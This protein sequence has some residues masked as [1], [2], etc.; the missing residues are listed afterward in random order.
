MHAPA[1]ADT[2]GH[3]S[4][5]GATRRHR[6]EIDGLRALAVSLV[7]AYHVFSGRVSGGVDVFLALS[8]FFLVFG[9][10]GQLRRTGEL[11]PLQSVSRTLSRLVPTAAVVLAGTTSAGL[12][13]MPENRWREL[14][15][16]LVASMTFTEN[17]LLVREAV[18]YSASNALASPMQ[19]FWSL[20][21]Q[22][23]VLVAAPVLAW[24]GV[25]L[26]RRSPWARHGHRIATAAVALVTGA[27]LLWSIHTTQADQQVAYFSMLPRLWELGAGALA[28]LLLTRVRPSAPV[29][30]VL[31][32]GGVLALVSCGALLDGA[33]QFPGW[34]AAWPVLS[35]V[36]VI[37][38]AHHGGPAG[39]HRFLSLPAMRWLGARSYALYLWHWPVLVLYLVLE[40]RE[41]PSAV[42][43]T[44][45]L[46][47]SVLLAAVTYRLVERPTAERLR[48]RRPLL[49]L[50]AVAAC[51]APLASGGLAATTWIERQADRIAAVAADPAYPGA[52]ALR[53]REVTTGGVPGVA[54]L[55]P[56][57]LIREDW[58]WLP[59]EATCTTE[60]R[61]GDPAPVEME[62]CVLGDDDRTRRVAVVGDSHAAQWLPPVAAIA[63]EEDWQV[64][65]IIRGGCTLSAGSEFLSED[66]PGYDECV[67]WQER[68][69]ERIVAL[70]PDLVLSTGT[71]TAPGEDSEWLPDGYLQA[72]RTLSDAGLR[73]IGLR[74]SPRH[75]EDVPDCMA[76]WGEDS[77]Q[78]AVPRASV[79]DDDLLESVADR[80]PAG[81]ALLDTSRYFCL[82][83]VCPALV[84][85][86]R[87]YMDSTHVTGT[88]MRTV[89]AQFREDLLSVIDW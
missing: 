1:L 73:I 21:I 32:W 49:A 3:R 8:G 47:L 81:V 68:L 37:V 60:V 78:C 26:V 63:E 80:L 4:D 44:V 65:S 71:R 54:P 35:A 6:A 27:S 67:A 30:A 7:V 82:D 15:S 79:Y 20:S 70:Q 12:W 25:L 72:W 77:E 41:T 59:P 46:G 53:T 64:V 58:P 31:G 57:M 38:A 14:A 19:Q 84:G 89:T 74:G 50:A 10:S 18:D 66:D 2:A 11:A 56:R 36:A 29:A 22:V 87:V 51:A 24:L 5:L 9:I 69:V 28:A 42:G 76:R 43:A 45:I 62:T 34:Q 23:Q 39:A 13:V 17:H 33:R 61:N 48:A 86:I 83:E 52:D 40:N 75:V 85:N 16:H 88:Y 55:P